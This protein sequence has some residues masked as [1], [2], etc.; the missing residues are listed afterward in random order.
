MP[1]LTRKST[2]SPRQRES[3]ARGHPIAGRPVAGFE[4]LWRIGDV[5]HYLGVPRS[6]VYKMTAPKSSNPIPHLKVGRLL[7][8]KKS[9]IDEWLSLWTVSSLETLE[10]VRGRAAR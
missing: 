4:R 1:S 9:D 2:P 3:V 5:A 8:F 6:A 7:R 10:R